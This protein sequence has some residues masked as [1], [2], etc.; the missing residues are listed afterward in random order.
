MSGSSVS[1]LKAIC[2]FPTFSW[3]TLCH[4][5]LICQEKSFLSLTRKSLFLAALNNIFQNWIGLLWGHWTWSASPCALR[6]LAWWLYAWNWKFKSNLL[7][8]FCIQKKEFRNYVKHPL[9]S[10]CVSVKCRCLVKPWSPY[11]SKRLDFNFKGKLPICL[12]SQQALSVCLCPLSQNYSQ[13]RRV[14]CWE[15]T[16]ETAAH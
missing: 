4:Q 3:S 9:S 15:H 1:P 8:H 2:F 14:Q 7:I 6:P 12:S 5:R 10:C 11:D 16:A 13:L